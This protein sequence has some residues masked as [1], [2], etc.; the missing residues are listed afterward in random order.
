MLYN[1]Y[2]LKIEA[3]N[4]LMGKEVLPSESKLFNLILCPFKE[5]WPRAACIR[6]QY[7]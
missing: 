1:F 2:R 3:I 7:F 6:G 5:K 4:K